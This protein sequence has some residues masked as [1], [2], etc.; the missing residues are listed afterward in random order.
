MNFP[1]PPNGQNDD[2]SAS[3]KQ[4]PDFSDI[5]LERRKVAEKQARNWFFILMGSGLLIGVIVAFGI[6]QLLQKFGLA[7]KPQNPTRIE[8]TQ[9]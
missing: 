7:D 9:N 3:V 5:P 8:Q 2:F 4:K 6:V 1:S